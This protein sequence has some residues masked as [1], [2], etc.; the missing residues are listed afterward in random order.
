[1]KGSPDHLWLVASLEVPCRP[2]SEG[3]APKE[4]LQNLSIRPPQFPWTLPPA[5]KSPAPH[6]PAPRC[7]VKGCVFPAASG[8]SGTCVQHGRQI[9]EPSLF[10][11]HQPSM[12]LL[13]RAKFGLFDSNS[14][15]T[16]AKD[17]RRMAKIRERLWDGAA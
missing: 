5:G 9:R 6:P 8:Y 10:L 1:M 7:N 4:S 13:D 11:S 15:D 17:R 14:D 3:F 2:L 16:R 12:L